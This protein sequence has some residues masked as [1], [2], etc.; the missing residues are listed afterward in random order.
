MEPQKSQNSAFAKVLSRKWSF[1]AAFFVILFVSASVLAVLDLLP[2][3]DEAA[4]EWEKP[5]LVAD[6]AHTM[7]APELPTHIEIPE[8]GLKA[9]IENPTSTNVAV[10]DR[11]L[12]T[13]AVR[14]PTSAK[15]GQEGNVIL[16]GHSSYLPIVNNQ[17]YKAFN[18][19]QELTAGDRI[20]VT[21]S[22]RTFVYEV[23]SVREA[24]A[25]EDAIPLTAVGN[26]LTLATCDSFGQ[27][28]DRFV[29]TAD[30]VE[31]Y[32]AGN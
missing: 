27:K 31:S 29:V 11:A 18:G 8:I 14:Y 5:A 13:G 17:S 23:V 25:E 22:S 28:S 12:N 6:S 7:V 4:G 19:I 16:F 20:F 10:L 1:L 2:E 3:S 9:A 32:P 24:D 15:L 30:L 26:R 21:G